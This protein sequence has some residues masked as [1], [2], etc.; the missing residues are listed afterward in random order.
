MIPKFC[1][2]E[3]HVDR[4]FSGLFYCEET[5]KKEHNFDKFTSKIIRKTQCDSKNQETDNKKT[6]IK[7][8]SKKTEFYFFWKKF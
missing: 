1:T 2:S 6:R 3:K 4:K 7:E 5:I 8:P